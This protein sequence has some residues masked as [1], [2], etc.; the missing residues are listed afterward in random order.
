[1]HFMQPSAS[2]RSQLIARADPRKSNPSIRKLS[3]DITSACA[4]CK[5][6]QSAPLRFKASIPAVRI[7]FKQVLYIETLWLHERPV[8]HVIADRSGFRS[9]A[10]L[11]VKSASIIWDLFIACWMTTFIGRHPYHDRYRPRIRRWFKGISNLCLTT[12]H[13]PLIHW[14]LITQLYR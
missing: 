8:L 2:K 14:F 3:E 7:I 4:S 10:F 12:W 5:T 6:C 1:M 11:T 13:Q 9:A